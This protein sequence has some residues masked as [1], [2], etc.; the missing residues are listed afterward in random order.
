MMKRLPGTET[1]WPDGGGF[2]WS[3]GLYFTRRDGGAVQVRRYTENHEGATPV[4]DV[5]VP[6]NEWASIVASME[7]G[8]ETAESWRA[9]LLRQTG[10]EFPR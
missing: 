6:P 2:H 4:L 8:G 3:D 10:G 5:T 9:A 1:T 7:S